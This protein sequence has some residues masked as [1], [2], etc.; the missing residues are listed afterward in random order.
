MVE[1]IISVDYNELLRVLL[2]VHDGQFVFLNYTT[3][4]EMN[5]GGRSHSNPYYGRI[6]K[7]VQS[8]VRP[9]FDYSDRVN[10]NRGKEGID[11]PFVVGENRVGEHVSP[12]VTF[13]EKLGRHYFMYEFFKEVK[14]MIEYT[15]D[16]DPIEKSLFNQYIVKKSDPKNQGVLR[17]V[18][19][20]QVNIDNINEITIDHTRYVRVR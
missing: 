8:R 12:C 5:K 9:L 4:E 2:Q 18:N 19:T 14:P 3:L 17:P 20:R 1:Q 15:C 6:K 13:N 11:T 16:G 7:H 10:N